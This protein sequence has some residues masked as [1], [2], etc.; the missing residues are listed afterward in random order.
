MLF[1]K[2]FATSRDDEDDAISFKLLTSLKVFSL[3]ISAIGLDMISFE[4]SIK[5]GLFEFSAPDELSALSSP[6]SSIFEIFLF[7]DV[8][9]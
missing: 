6:L 7:I 9:A 8:S 2:L 1:T 5:L 4:V 3:I